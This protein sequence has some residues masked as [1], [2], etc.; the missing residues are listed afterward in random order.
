MRLNVFSWKVA[1]CVF[2]KVISDRSVGG[3]PW[4]FLLASRA[5][6]GVSRRIE[7]VPYSHDRRSNRRGDREGVPDVAGEQASGTWVRPTAESWNCIRAL[8]LHDVFHRPLVHRVRR[9][10]PPELF[11]RFAL[12]DGWV[13]DGMSRPDDPNWALFWKLHF[14]LPQLLLPDLP[15]SNSRA[16]LRLLTSRFYCFEDGRWAEL[17]EPLPGMRRPARQARAPPPR[18]AGA[19]ETIRSMVARLLADN[20]RNRAMQLLVSHGVYSRADLV[21][22]L[23]A[24]HP[25]AADSAVTAA[26]E[27]A[28]W[29]ALLTDV[30]GTSAFELN[31]DSWWTAMRSSS[32]WS[33]GGP[34]LRV[35]EHLKVALL[36]NCEFPKQAW[37][38]V[39]TLVAQGQLPEEIECFYAAAS[40]G[41]L[42][43]DADREGI[44]PI[45]AGENL[46]RLVGRAM[47]QQSRE[48]IAEFF[49]PLGQVGVGPSS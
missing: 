10:P 17:L 28:S 2:C 32:K 33:M 42:F 38:R 29:N 23:Q 36:A 37:F 49:L 19:D 48:R 11:D 27:R 14:L 7:N 8:D 43:K 41:G 45:A 24:L 30:P 16:T 31:P 47:L 15:R 12:L 20:E 34:S 44:R 4:D 9:F 40:L 35:N 6:P 1:C 39:A 25:P 46:R 5:W 18:P 26:A 3:G 21:S 13:A 22:K